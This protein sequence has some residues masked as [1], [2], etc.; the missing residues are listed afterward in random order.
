[1]QWDHERGLLVSVKGLKD[2]LLVS[3]NSQTDGGPWVSAGRWD[4]SWEEEQGTL[5]SI[6][7][8]TPIRL[9]KTFGAKWLWL[10]F[11]FVNV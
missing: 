8:S 5:G 9:T 11:F 2:G 7:V 4:G 6:H 10:H 3:V 1:M